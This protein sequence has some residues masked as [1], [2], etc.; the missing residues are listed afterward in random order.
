MVCSGIRHTV[1]VFGKE[2]QVNSAGRYR[3][4]EKIRKARTMGQGLEITWKKGFSY[5]LWRSLHI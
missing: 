4:G 1:S 2:K 5:F 3:I